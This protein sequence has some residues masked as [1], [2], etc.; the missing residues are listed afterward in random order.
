MRYYPDLSRFSVMTRNKKSIFIF[1]AF[2]VIVSLNLSWAH[3]TILIQ[4]VGLK[5]YYDLAVQTPFICRILP[6]LLY[7]VVFF[8][9]G[10]VSLGLNKPLSSSYGLFQIILDTTSLLLTLLF[11]IKITRFLN[12]LLPKAVIYLF[13]SAVFL[14]IIVFG[15]FMVPNSAMFYPY[16]FPDLCL[17]TLIFYLAIST[18][19]LQ[20]LVL[21]LAIFVATMNKETAAFYFGLYL[22]FR[23]NNTS[24]WKLTVGVAFASITSFVLARSLVLLFVS[25]VTSRPT[26]L[27]SQYVFHLL[28]STLPELKNP[29]LVFAMLNVCSYL[30]VPILFLRKS[31]DRTDKLILGMAGVWF[32]IM[33]N[34]GVIRELRLFAPASLMLFVILAR[35]LDFFRVRDG[36]FH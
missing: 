9:H 19:G 28:D 29:L 32:L 21:P 35:H 11:M 14:M 27:E 4:Q 8:G 2:A 13:S 18:R 34:V 15:F 23:L 25:T 10:E 30:Y 7:R 6:A 33:A 31:L 3:Q 24:N 26:S 5:Q 20:E 1:A 17:A 22:I 36:K 12:L 16:D